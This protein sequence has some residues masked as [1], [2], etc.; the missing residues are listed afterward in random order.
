MKLSNFIEM[1]THKQTRI[2]IFRR[3]QLR[4]LF[5]RVGHTN[6]TYC[7]TLRPM[8]FREQNLVSL[9]K[10]SSDENFHFPFTNNVTKRGLSVSKKMALM[11]ITSCLHVTMKERASFRANP[12]HWFVLSRLLI[13]LVLHFVSEMNS[14]FGCVVG[15]FC[16]NITVARWNRT[17]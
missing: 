5:L 12:C 9:M 16:L 15:Q 14:Y 2:N 4:S 3:P 6:N 17:W 8:I 1:T 7:T 10:V 13:L 11:P